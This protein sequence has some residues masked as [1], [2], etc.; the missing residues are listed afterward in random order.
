MYLFCD[1]RCSRRYYCV[2]L[3]GVMGTRE[4]LF[5]VEWLQRCGSTVRGYMLRAGSTYMVQITL[6]VVLVRTRNARRVKET[7]KKRAKRAKKQQ[8]TAKSSK[9]YNRASDY[10]LLGWAILGMYYLYNRYELTHCGW[11]HNSGT[12]N[13]KLLQVFPV[14]P[15]SY[16]LL[17][18]AGYHS[19]FFGG[20]GTKKPRNLHTPCSVSSPSLYLSFPFLS[21][22][23]TVPTTNITTSP[24]HDYY[25]I[26]TTT[27]S[28][29]YNNNSSSIN[30][31]TDDPIII[32]HP[33]HRYQHWP[34]T[35]DTT[36]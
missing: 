3:Y 17:L 22:I 1:A 4:V 7:R 26:T 35:R 23:I 16:D 10:F 29:N 20:Q 6:Y 15:H 36:E 28:A 19:Y 24:N 34:H 8:K 21:I 2:I 25:S 11:V 31:L 32:I 12:T 13:Q 9:K 18:H 5:L 27:S 30:N 14:L 33:R